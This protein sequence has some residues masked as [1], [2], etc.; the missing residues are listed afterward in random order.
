MKHGLHASNAHL[1]PL[2]H[3]DG[4]SDAASVPPPNSSSMPPASMPMGD[5]LADAGRASHLTTSRHMRHFLLS[6]EIHT[7]MYPTDELKAC[8][9]C[10]SL[11][12]TYVCMQALSRHRLE[13]AHL[14]EQG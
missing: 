11:C 10:G 4:P 7:A 8:L 3:S 2:T 13:A 6:P 12:I 9:I 14:T 5:Q 1:D